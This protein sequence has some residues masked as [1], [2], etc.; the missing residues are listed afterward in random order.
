MNLLQESN[1]MYS[2]VLF[3]DL[4]CWNLSVDS[5]FF[6]FSYF[7]FFSYTYSYS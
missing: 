5:V 7:L 4:H 1:H 3:A 6:S 2:L